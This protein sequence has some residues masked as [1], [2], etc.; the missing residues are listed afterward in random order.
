MSSTTSVVLTTHMVGLV[1]H[2]VSVGIFGLSCA[3]EHVDTLGTSSEASNSAHPHM[4]IFSKPGLA[5]IAS[6]L[7]NT[8]VSLRTWPRL[9]TADWPTQGLHRP[10]L[11]VPAGHP[12]PEQRSRRDDHVVRLRAVPELPR[13]GL[14]RKG[15][16]GGRV[17]RSV[18]RCRPFGHAN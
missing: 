5:A 2:L 12:G 17:W 10:H 1:A 18:V 13:G 8:C 4:L 6:P 16:G 3:P 11:S 14:L 15:C 9:C 7:Q